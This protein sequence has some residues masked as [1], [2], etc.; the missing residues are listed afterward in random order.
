MIYSQYRTNTPRPVMQDIILEQ[1][2]MNSYFIIDAHGEVE[3]LPE[4][5]PER[6]YVVL[7]CYG[8]VFKNLP[9]RLFMDSE[10][11]PNKPLGV[12]GFE[13]DLGLEKLYCYYDVKG[14]FHIGHR[15]RLYCFKNDE[16]S[17]ITD[18]TYL[19]EMIS[20]INDEKLSN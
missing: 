9:Y 12:P 16:G 15:D 5:I 11:A 19:L 6:G 7:E 20:F 10:K 13:L 14:I 2:L 1:V 18:I 4:D 3:Y 17:L 8:D